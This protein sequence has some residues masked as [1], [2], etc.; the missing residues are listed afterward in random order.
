MKFNRAQ[1]RRTSIISAIFC[2]QIFVTHDK[3]AHCEQSF[4]CI[5]ASPLDGQILT[6]EKTLSVSN[7]SHVYLL[8]LST[9]RFR[10]VKTLS[11]SNRSRVYPLF[12]SKV[13]FRH[14]KKTRTVSS[15]SDVLLLGLGK[16]VD[17]KRSGVHLLHLSITAL[18]YLPLFCFFAFP[19]EEVSDAVKA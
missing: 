13:R 17:C 16:D 8:L 2:C 14:M 15:S 7:R 6:S 10:P 4:T 9:V 12:L 18:Q 1:F 5:P 11:V 3:N 19:H